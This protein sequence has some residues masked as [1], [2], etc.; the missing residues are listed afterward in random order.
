MKFCIIVKSKKCIWMD[1]KN[2]WNKSQNPEIVGSGG[3][4]EGWIEAIEQNEQR[5]D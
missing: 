2:D 5:K 4:K 1:K 3:I